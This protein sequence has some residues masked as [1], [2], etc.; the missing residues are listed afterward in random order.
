MFISHVEHLWGAMEPEL[1]NSTGYFLH[2]W[3][4]VNK[5]PNPQM[6]TWPRLK[7]IAQEVRGKLMFWH[8]GHFSSL[9]NPLFPSWWQ[10]L[11]FC[12]RYHTGRRLLN[13]PYQ[14]ETVWRR[15]SHIILWKKVL[16]QNQL[17][18]DSMIPMNSKEWLLEVLAHITYYHSAV[19]IFYSHDI[20][21]FDML[22]ICTPVRHKR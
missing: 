10:S 6:V 3:A 19:F 14:Q 15:Q 7:D 22:Y 21:H 12:C 8:Q 20:Q 13:C 2:S 18:S 17:R 4:Q 11:G 5:S 1:C 16:R 9:G